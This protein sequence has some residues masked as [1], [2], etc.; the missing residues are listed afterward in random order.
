MLST[1]ADASSSS[2]GATSS[3]VGVLLSVLQW[4]IFVVGASGNLLVLIVVAASRRPS[5]KQASTHVLL[6]SV[7]V[8]NVVWMMTSGWSQALLLID[9][10]WRFGVALCKIG[11]T[12]QAT[13][14]W[15]NVWI[16][17]ILALDRYAK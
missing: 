10:D 1:V 11:Y 8:V 6:A 4:F 9:D 2:P 3:P 17:A 14:T 16:L 7:A 12:L 5:P 13:M 15:T